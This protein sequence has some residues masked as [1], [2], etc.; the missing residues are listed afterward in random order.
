MSA[1][2]T[3]AALTLATLT[4]ENGDFHANFSGF[5]CIAL[6]LTKI[7]SPSGYEVLSLLTPP[8]SSVIVIVIVIVIV[9]VIVVVI[10]V[11]ILTHHHHHHHYHQLRRYLLWL[12]CTA[13]QQQRAINV[14]SIQIEV[15]LTQP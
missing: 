6:W 13:H 10:V 3:L 11:V 4:L 8:T 9:F 7:L 2:L 1:T 14:E 12:P 15:V 5:S